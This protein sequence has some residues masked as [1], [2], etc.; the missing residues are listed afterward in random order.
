MDGGGESVRRRTTEGRGRTCRRGV[1]S[2]R[3]EAPVGV[4][5]ASSLGVFN[6]PYE[7][8]TKRW[9]AIPK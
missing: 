7:R 8:A 6:K 2:K 3:E 1:G 9:G 5:G 4:T